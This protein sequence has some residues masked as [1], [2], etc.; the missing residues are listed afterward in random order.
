MNEETEG[1][2]GED[3]LFHDP[4]E[5]TP[6]YQSIQEELNRLIVE[7]IGE[8]GG[9]GYCRRYW[10]AKQAILLERYNMEWKS[11]D[12]LNTGIIFD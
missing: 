9:I 11:P 7:Q 10:R 2:L 12:E 4:L 3:G 6:E 5:D 1:V 8:G